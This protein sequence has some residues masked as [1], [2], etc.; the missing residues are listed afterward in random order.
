[1]A[2]PFPRSLASRAPYPGWFCG[3]PRLVLT[4]LALLPS[5]PPH[6]IPNIPHLLF[7]PPRLPF[8]RKDARSLS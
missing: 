4:P 3:T 2:T 6:S 1:M 8:A 7:P 5:F